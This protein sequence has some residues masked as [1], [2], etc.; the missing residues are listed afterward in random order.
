MCHVGVSYLVPDQKG[1]S[2]LFGIFSTL[3][4]ITKTNLISLTLIAT[5]FFL[6]SCSTASRNSSDYQSVVIEHRTKK[7]IVKDLAVIVGNYGY[8]LFSETASEVVFE[9]QP[10]KNNEIAYAKYDKNYRN[11][12]YSGYRN[13]NIKLPRYQIVFDFTTVDNGFLIESKI[14]FISWQHL[15]DQNKNKKEGVEVQKILNE[16]KYN[17]RVDSSKIN[18]RKYRT[19]HQ[20]LKYTIRTHKIKSYRRKNYVRKV[21]LSAIDYNRQVK[22][23]LF[24]RE[25]LKNYCNFSGGTFTDKNDNRFY[26]SNGVKIPNSFYN[27]FNRANELRAFGIK[28]CVSV[29]G[30]LWRL[31]IK[32]RM[33]KPAK[34]P[35]SDAVNVAVSK[36]PQLYLYIQMLANKLPSFMREKG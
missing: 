32:P 15:Y 10:D 14:A 22:A 16:L 17:S 19:I 6:I 5:T 35:D 7:E 28:A 30:V 11:N 4:K 25:E 21:I 36:N 20:F 23:L 13:R 34:K 1:I 12:Y 24:V 9:T 3:K 2:I 31:V 8:K 18:Y 26:S 29:H 33:I 27:S